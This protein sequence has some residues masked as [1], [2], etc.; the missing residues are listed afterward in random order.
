MSGQPEE[1]AGVKKP[2]LT[3]D[4]GRMDKEFAA[5][6]RQQASAL[7]R[8]LHEEG[9]HRRLRD[10]ELIAGG[11]TDS[12][13]ASQFDIPEDVVPD[14]MVYQWIAYEV[15]GMPH[16][17]RICAA[18]ERTGWR[19]VPASRHPGMWTEKSY[20][21]PIEIGGQRLYEL[22]E[23]EAY[24]RHRGLYLKAKIQR[25]DSKERLAMAPAGTGPRSH[26]GIRPQVA[27]TR[28]A[29]PIE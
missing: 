27:V 8:P 26:P 12:T 7:Q 11:Y 15:D 16:R 2:R 25:Q 6:A 23:T 29:L 9:M 13:E 3:L 1:S 28:E 10:D 17:G 5:E 19:P 4:A 24:N 14:G 21:G 22:P 18:A 20:E